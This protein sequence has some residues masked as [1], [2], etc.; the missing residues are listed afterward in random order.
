MRTAIKSAL[1]VVF[2]CGLLCGCGRF[3]MRTSQEVD[4]IW[5][6]KKRVEDA[7]NSGDAAT[8]KGMFAEDPVFVICNGPVVEGRDAIEK[9]HVE[10][11]R[12]NPGFKTEFK[13]QHIT[14]PAR[15]VAIETV[16]FTDRF[17]GQPLRYG[18]DTTVYVKEGG[19]WKN[20]YIRMHTSVPS[21]TPEKPEF[22]RESEAK[23]VWEVRLAVQNALRTENADALIKLFTEDAAFYVP[24]AGMSRGKEQIRKAHEQLFE[25]FDNIKFEFKRLAI[26]FPTPDVAIE[27]V[28]YVFTATGLESHSRDTTV[29]VK[30]QGR[31]WITAVLDLIPMAPAENFI[32]QTRINTQDDITTI[33]KLED[34]FLAAHAFND[35]AKLAAF[36]TDD[37]LLIPPDEQTVRGKQAI[38]AWYDN[39]FKKAPPIENPKATLEEIEIRG[40]LAFIRGNFI[41][42]FKGKTPDTPNIQN[43]RFISIWRKQPD[44][45]W[46]F[47]CDIWNTNSLLPPKEQNISSPEHSVSDDSMPLTIAT[48]C[49]NVKNDTAVNLKTFAKYIEQASQKGAQLIVFPEIALQ[50]NPGWLA[51]QVSEDEMAYVHRTAETIPGPSTAALTALSGQYNIHIIFGMTEK[52]ANDDLYNASVLLGP[53]GVIGKYRKQHI[54]SDKRR[55]GNEE[56]FWKP[57]TEMGLFETPF[58]RIGIM[59]CIEMEDHFGGELADLGADILVTTTAWRGDINKAVVLYERYTKSNAFEAQRWHIVSNQVGP[60]GYVTGYGHS[61]VVNP[62]GEVV[63]DTGDKEGMVVVT[64]DLASIKDPAS[65]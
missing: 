10:F 4:A 12:E 33:H 17:P 63:A 50:Q 46:K 9:M 60:V 54:F 55:G 1:L 19:Q 23:A 64:T 6:V 36:Y 61:R 27:D 2:V 47:Y 58:G 48:V 5:E 49:M 56:L 8:L 53:D 15:N 57:G 37:A 34:E 28:S 38:A 21:Q 16:S 26:N 30:R 3:S 13:R 44:E 42:K 45:N 52:S 62:N 32:E 24:N 18:G 51:P 35:G 20:K 22:D 40:D 65:R 31:W 29:L 39:E 41:L 14:F 59:T 25:T 43:L 7:L 11:F